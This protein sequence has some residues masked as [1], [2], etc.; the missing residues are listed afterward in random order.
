MS[1]MAHSLGSVLTY[2]V[3]CNQPQLDARTVNPNPTP[4][5]PAAAP[6]S[7]EDRAASAPGRSAAAGGQSAVEG[8]GSGSGA[9]LSGTKGLRAEP[10]LLPLSSADLG[11]PVPSAPDQALECYSLHSAEVCRDE[12]GS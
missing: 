11:L 5:Q 2:D 6:Q 10:S 1:V 8:S 9:G 12:P 3:L 4:D 7:T